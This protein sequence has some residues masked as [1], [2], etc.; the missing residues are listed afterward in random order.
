MSWIEKRKN[1]LLSFQKRFRDTKI[2]ETKPI[3]IPDGLFT[4]CVQ[5]QTIVYNKELEENLYVCPYCDY[6]FRLKARKR[7]NSI[8]DQDSFI[9][10]IDNLETGNPLN[11]PQY[12]EKLTIGKQMSK[13]DEAFI[14]GT[15][16]IAKIPV[17]IGVLDSFFMMGSMGS[18]VGEKITRLIEHAA[19]NNLPLIIFSASGGAR[20]QE[21]ILSLMQMA[22]T[23][24]ALNKLSNKG[25]L[26]ISI[27]TNPTMG[28]VAASYAMLGDIIIVEKNALVG[29]AGSRV[30]KQTI[31]QDLPEGF[32]TASFQVSYG[33]VD[34]RVKRPNMRKVITQVLELHNY[35][36]GKEVVN[37]VT[38]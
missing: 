12:E 29:F 8:V 15:A 5:C 21:G 30:I 4:Q 13:L 27:L 23:S 25:H 10:T 34:M 26:Y 2:K 28:G 33:Q 35:L 7:I 14:Y 17:A 37:D 22:K 24:G 1:Q 38:K 9:E 6:H 32:Q 18:V 16:K 3:D 31:G 19:E 36:P 11:M 20:M